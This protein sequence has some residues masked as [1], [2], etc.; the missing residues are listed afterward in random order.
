M[1]MCTSGHPRSSVRERFRIPALFR[2]VSDLIVTR[3][4]LRR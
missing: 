4:Y 2:F 1:A 3:A